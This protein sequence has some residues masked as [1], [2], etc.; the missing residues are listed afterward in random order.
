M[1]E[2]FGPFDPGPFYDREEIILI[3][4]HAYESFISDVHG[5]NVSISEYIAN[6]LVAYLDE[7]RKGQKHE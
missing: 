5:E 7:K 2:D 6:H 3:I 4:S 1:N